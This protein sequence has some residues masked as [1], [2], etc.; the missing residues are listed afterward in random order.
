M[1]QRNHWLKGLRTVHGQKSLTDVT[2]EIALCW[3]Y[4][5]E[6][7]LSWAV[8]QKF[9]SGW[10]PSHTTMLHSSG[11]HSVLL[12][13]PGSIIVAVHCNTLSTTPI[14]EAALSLNFICMKDLVG[15]LFTFSSFS[16]SM[17]W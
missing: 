15:F 17:K 16:V 8:S 6:G 14:L 3:C 7:S 10:L 12:H 2:I 9:S 4:K 1:V 5:A 13:G 11:L